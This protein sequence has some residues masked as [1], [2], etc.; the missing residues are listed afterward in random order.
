MTCVLKP[1]VGEI[2]EK[3]TRIL[4]DAEKAQLE[5]EFVGKN[6]Q[7]RKMEVRT[8]SEVYLSC[9]DP[10]FADDYGSTEIE[11]VVPIRDQVAGYVCRAVGRRRCLFSLLSQ[12]S[13]I[14]STRGFREKICLQKASQN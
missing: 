6:G 3:A 5:V 10:A 8:T 2:L 12:G 9:I 13:I 11:E 14:A 4:T 7:R 1:R